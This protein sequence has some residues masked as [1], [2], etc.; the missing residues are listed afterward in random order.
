ME[1]IEV[2]R[3]HVATPE[4]GIKVSQTPQDEIENTGW[5]TFS[6]KIGSNVHMV[7]DLDE[8]TIKPVAPFLKRQV[9]E[10]FKRFIEQELEKIQ[11]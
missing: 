2:L 4:S 8:N 6:I 3:K 9:L 7:A 1:L 11:T 10:S 5:F